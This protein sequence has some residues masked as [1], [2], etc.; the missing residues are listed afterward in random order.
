MP[1]AT[2]TTGDGSDLL[3]PFEQTPEA[4]DADIRIFAIRLAGEGERPRSL[5]ADR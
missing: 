5:T 3:D 4:G 1:A 2:M